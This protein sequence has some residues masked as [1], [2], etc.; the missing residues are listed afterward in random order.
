[1]ILPVSA[2]A[3]PPSMNQPDHHE[4]IVATGRFTLSVVDAA[5][6]RVVK[7]FKP[8]K[9]LLL[10]SGLDFLGGNY[11]WEDC[12]AYCVAGTG[13]TPTRDTHETGTYE[14]SGTN[15]HRVD[16]DRDFISGDV[17]K[18]LRFA[19][20]EEAYV[21]AFVDA[22]NV[23]VGVSRTVAA[24]TIVLYRVAQTGLA[25]ESSR[26]NT[27][28]S[29]TDAD[30]G[31]PATVTYFDHPNAVITHKVTTDFAELVSPVNYTEVG[32]SPSGSAG[33]NL[34]CRILL[35]G[36]V[37]VGV[38]QLL[39]VKYELSLTVVPE[40]D[41]VDGGM[42]GWP[43]EYT[44][45]S[46]TSTVSNFTVTLNKAHHYEIGGKINLSGTKRPRTAITAAAS[47]STT[48][49]FTAVGHGRSPGDTIVV[50]DMTPSGYNG[51][52]TVATTPDADTITVTN[53]ANPGAGT[54]FGNL[55]QKEPVTWYDGEWTIASKTST[56][57]T[58]TS[59]TNPPDAGADGTCVNNVKR[60]TFILNYGVQYIPGATINQELQAS[61]GTAYTGA[62]GVAAIRGGVLEGAPTSGIHGMRGGVVLA[63]ST[64]TP[65][66][67]PE[68]Y[69][70][71]GAS[72]SRELGVTGSAVAGN[73]PDMLSAGVE[74]VIGTTQSYTAGNHYRDYTI[75]FGAGT[76][77]SQAINTLLF[78]PNFGVGETGAITSLVRFDELQRKDNTHKLTV[79]L[80]RSWGRLIGEGVS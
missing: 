1:M 33:N 62:G 18:L 26:S 7:K 61:C 43:Y 13:N 53:A 20:G 30:D 42:T 14:Q 31:R 69:G 11:S 44:V 17:G 56:T 71:I 75:T 58:V 21:T 25:A 2:S 47:N 16:G 9:N 28:P 22:D 38:G 10:D 64:T 23:T 80:R 55:R 50:E 29:Y 67:F 52:W 4:R 57:V 39:R 65:L 49:T 36:A 74:F 15:V 54:D 41:T 6:G 73:L 63:K 37:T 72:A 3:T 70:S 27:R 5:T 24:T 60:K 32:M 40:G 79:T 12:L 8:Q 59:A 77:N 68:Y 78:G 35:P 19:S 46:I 51:E 76:G 45:T 66:S 48:F 34:F